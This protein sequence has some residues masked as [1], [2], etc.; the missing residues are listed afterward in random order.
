MN[1]KAKKLSIISRILQTDDPEVLDTVDRLLALTDNSGA[2]PGNLDALSFTSS[3]PVNSDPEVQD[4][5][6]SIDAIFQPQVKT[7]EDTGSQK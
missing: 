4:L 2:G 1:L 7:G 6:Q 3:F 5:Q